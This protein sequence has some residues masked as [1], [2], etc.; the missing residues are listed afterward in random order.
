MTKRSI[1]KLKVAC[2]NAHGTILK[3]HMVC[4]ASQK[5]VDNDFINFEALIRNKTNTFISRWTDGW[6][7][8]AVDMT[9]ILYYEDRPN[10]ALLWTIK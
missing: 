9:L 1:M 5:Y 10:T 2:N 6:L 7:Y 8:N 4:S 3:L